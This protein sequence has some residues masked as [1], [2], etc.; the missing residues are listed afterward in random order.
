MRLSPADPTMLDMRDA[1]LQADQVINDG[2]HSREL[3]RVFAGRGMGWYAG[4]VDGGDASPTESFRVRPRSDA[5]TGVISGTLTDDQTGEPLSG[6][7]VVV[8]GHDGRYSATTRAD[9]GFDIRGVLPGTYRKVST[10]GRGYAGFSRQVTVR[11]G[12][13]RDVTASLRRDWAASSEGADVVAFTGPDFSAYGC[14]PA[15]AVDLQQ[16]SGWSSVTG[17]DDA[18]PTSSPVPK[19]VDIEL[20]EPIDIAAGGEEGATAFRIDPSS[21]CG[22]PGSAS[23]ND[24]RIEVSTDG[25]AW[26]EV[27]DG[28]FGT[29]PATSRG[30]Y[31]DVPALVSVAAVTHVRFWMES[32][33]V[34]DISID[35]PDGD[36]AGC[37]HM[38]VSEIQVFGRP[39]SG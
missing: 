24:Y 1:I 30:A 20:S 33:Q 39:T 17:A 21:T 15:A 3:W 8:A 23:T 10:G 14:G 2:A 32:P 27:A 35:C 11:S 26:V 29:D 13:V 28:A 5:A 31:V 34:P 12:R 25:V 38:D 9:G 4:A 19:H 16:G 6:I 36:Y 7:R 18:E 22:D 37:T